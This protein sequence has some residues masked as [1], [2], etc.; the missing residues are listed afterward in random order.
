MLQLSDEKPEQLKR[1][2]FSRIEKHF[3]IRAF[4]EDALNAIR[5]L[6]IY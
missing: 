2:K 1:L 5:E 3:L 6:L 4:R